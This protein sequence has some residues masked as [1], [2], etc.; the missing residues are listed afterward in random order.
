MAEI[1]LKRK[2]VLA[3]PERDPM[4]ISRKNGQA[5]MEYALIMIA[6]TVAIIFSFVTL[7]RAGHIETQIGGDMRNVWGQNSGRGYFDKA[8]NAMTGQ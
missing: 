2:P 8:L 3:R 1:K 6:V 4:F 7:I 5:I